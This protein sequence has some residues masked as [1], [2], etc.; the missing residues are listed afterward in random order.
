VAI[1]YNAGRTSQ[2]NNSI[3]LNAT[4]ANLNQTTAN[5]FTVAPVRNDVANIG[6]V[7]FYNTASK[8]I[9]YGNTINVA[10]NITGGN[11]SVTGN[12]TGNTNGFAIGYLDI[13]QVTWSANATIGLTD[14]GKHYYT[15]SASNLTLTVANSATANF[16]IGSAINIVNLGTGTMSIL[17]GGG[18]TMYYAGNST[19]GN[20]TLASYGVAT[21]QKVATDTW[22]VVGVGIV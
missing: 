9:T 6:E 3:I 12:I 8:E 13:P 22:F 16:S 4:G 1:G 5:T 7:V 2:G 18:V 20:R 19:A 21:I 15:T 11:L 17:Q 14:S 10:G